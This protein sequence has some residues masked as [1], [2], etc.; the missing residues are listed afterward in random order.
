M[1]ISLLWVM[2]SMVVS[3]SMTDANSPIAIYFI[4]PSAETDAN[5]DVVVPDAP[6]LAEEADAL[7][8]GL[9]GFA[10]FAHFHEDSR[11]IR[12]ALAELGIQP[13]QRREARDR[14]G[15]VS[16][17]HGGHA[18]FEPDRGVHHVHRELIITRPLANRLQ[19]PCSAEYTPKNRSG[20]S[21]SCL[22]CASRGQNDDWTVPTLAPIT[23]GFSAVLR[24]DTP[25]RAFRPS[26]SRGLR[27]IHEVET[28]KRRVGRLRLCV[29]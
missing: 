23:A 8:R 13:K 3:P 5:R 24:S 10:H 27:A 1:G 20:R 9:V 12:P 4:K 16:R 7:P 21:R 17:A 2:A 25:S 28:W 6:V 15:E 11:E 22:T 18:A 29:R 19:P 26:P 14:R